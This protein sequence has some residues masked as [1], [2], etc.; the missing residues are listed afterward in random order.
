[1]L[2]IERQAPPTAESKDVHVEDVF[3]VDDSKP[4]T[5]AIT[6]RTSA[7]PT[8]ALSVTTNVLRKQFCITVSIGPDKLS[9]ETVCRQI[10]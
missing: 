4:S 8:D 10:V 1:M 7:K 2:E 9:Y 6:S 3:D 5:T